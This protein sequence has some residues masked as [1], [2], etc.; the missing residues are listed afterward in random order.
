VADLK[1]TVDAFLYPLADQIPDDSCCE[2]LF[3]I[4]CGA[5]QRSRI[6]TRGRQGFNHGC[7]IYTG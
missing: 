2:R 1:Q 4:T 6:S 7:V 3:S 5:H